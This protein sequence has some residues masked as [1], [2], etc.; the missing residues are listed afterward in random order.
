MRCLVL[1]LVLLF[2]LMNVFVLSR[3]SHRR[4]L[5]K[6][7]Q[8]YKIQNVEITRVR[9]KDNEIYKGA[10]NVDDA[11]EDNN[12]IS[13]ELLGDIK[14]EKTPFFVQRDSK[15]ILQLHRGLCE[16]DKK[17][18]S[19]V[20]CYIRY[21]LEL[22]SISL[23]F[24]EDAKEIFNKFFNTDTLK[25]KRSV[26]FNSLK[27]RM[28]KNDFPNELE[29]KEFA[30]MRKIEMNL[31]DCQL[32]PVI[33]TRMGFGKS[34]KF[35]EVPES[36]KT[37]E[38]EED[39]M[40]LKNE[41]SN[42]LIGYKKI[43][44]N[45]SEIETQEAEELIVLNNEINKGLIRYKD[46][47]NYSS[48]IDKQKTKKLDELLRNID[49]KLMVHLGINKTKYESFSSNIIEFFV[50]YSREVYLKYLKNL[51]VEDDKNKNI[52]ITILNHEI[53]NLKY[54]I[55]GSL[56]NN[57][58]N[59]SGYSKILHTDVEVGEI[60]VEMVQKLMFLKK[61]FQTKENLFLKIIGDLDKHCWTYFPEMMDTRD[62]PDQ[63]KRVRS[64]NR[65]KEYKP[66]GIGKIHEADRIEHI[67]LGDNNNE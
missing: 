47:R 31:K 3:N 41:L 17:N 52:I 67:P 44:N 58:L 27:Q 10:V 2:A 6:T 50:E 32:S 16:R 4:K 25:Q 5:T 40:A 20:N 29:K 30:C 12:I 64:R 23:T 51:F 62:N 56:F 53:K 39:L 1:V 65:T 7:K 34:L 9:F 66:Y 19:I 60:N 18:Q 37:Q 45:L 38:A 8:I 13:L 26:Y 63:D 43:L 54:H 11:E 48:E 42:D 61:E 15:T 22:I 59:Y 49:A 36:Y 21:G 46:V 55:E 33:Q 24:P 57:P 35:L 14:E 28:E